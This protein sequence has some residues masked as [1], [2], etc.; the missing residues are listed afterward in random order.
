MRIGRTAGVV[1]AVAAVGIAVGAAVSTAGWAA[2]AKKAAAPA[3][4][5]QPSM[6]EMMA[7]MQ[8]VAAPGREHEILKNYEGKWTA[9]VSMTMDPAQPPQVSDG[10]TEGMVMMGGRY[11]HVLHHSTMMGQPFEGMM[12]LGYDN[13]AKKYTAVWVDTM[14]TAIVPYEGQY[15]TA[16]KA[17]VL[18]STFTDPMSGKAMHTRGVQ[19]FVDANTM[20]Y[21][22]YMPGP[23]GKEVH[24]LHIDYKRA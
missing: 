2:D 13:Q 5:K 20:T 17:L 24:M 14:G 1:A 10:T 6:D 21:D 7:A 22:E 9:K 18:K 23:D 8:K 16:K 12:L 15:D 19:T 4:A 11:V 3:A